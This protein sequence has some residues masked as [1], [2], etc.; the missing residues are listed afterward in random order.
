MNQSIIIKK[1]NQR[2]P[3]GIQVRH[4]RRMSFKYIFDFLLVCIRTRVSACMFWRVRA[5]T[6]QSVSV[7][8]CKKKKKK[9]VR[10]GEMQYGPQTYTYWIVH[11][12]IGLYTHVLDCAHTYWVVHTRIGVCTHVLDCTLY[13][14]TEG[15]V[16]KYQWWASHW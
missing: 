3:V 13:R 14:D 12:R 7:R 6:C 15:I 1:N 2:L 9:R 4:S 5:F 16:G 8:A 10:R 11:S